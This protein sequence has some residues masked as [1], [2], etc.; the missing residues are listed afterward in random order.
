MSP[1]RIEP[2]SELGILLSM[3]KGVLKTA[4]KFLNMA[5]AADS[6]AITQLFLNRVV[7]NYELAAGAD[8]VTEDD[9]TTMG[10]LDL[11]NGMLGA[12]EQGYGYL[13]AVW[14]EGSHPFILRFELATEAGDTRE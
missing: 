2:D 13:R 10:F 12:G 9:T 5:L 8:I 14:T 7:C 11:L 4:L 6:G 3:K 1:T